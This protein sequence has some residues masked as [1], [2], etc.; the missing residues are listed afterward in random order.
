MKALLIDDHAMVREGVTALLR[1]AFPDGAIL[2]A[3]DITAAIALA[4]D[5]EDL[6][7]AVLDLMMPGLSGIPAL[8]A[9]VDAQPTVPVIVLSSSEDVIDVRA[10]LA[11]GAL[12]YVAKSASPATLL[13][14]VRLV[15]SGEI[16]VPTFVAQGGSAP[17]AALAALTDRQRDVLRLVAAEAS[18]KEIA[19]RLAISEKTVKAHLTTIFARLAVSNRAEATRALRGTSL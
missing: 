1:Q 15:L 6:E 16:Y 3:G 7:L 10:A 19:Y 5:H 4:R 8:T 14:A 12:G 18:N 13:A 9:F 2:Q 17:A 11:A